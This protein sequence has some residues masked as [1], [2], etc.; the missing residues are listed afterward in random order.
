LYVCNSIHIHIHIEKIS[1]ILSSFETNFNHAVITALQNTSRPTV[2]HIIKKIPCILFKEYIKFL[3][4]P[5][6]MP[7][8]ADKPD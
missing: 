5:E 4:I 8:L 1:V 7:D 2:L 3:K 6:F